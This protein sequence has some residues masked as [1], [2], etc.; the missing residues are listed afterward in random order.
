MTLWP[1]I[2]LSVLYGGCVGSFLNVVIYRLPAGKSLVRPGS[3]CPQCDRSLRW[4]ENIPILSWLVLRARCRSCGASI[5]VQ[6]PLVEAVCAGLFGITLWIYFGTTLRP[7]FFDAGPAATWPLLLIHLVL[8][9]ALLAASVID[10]KLFI[11]PLDIPCLVTVVALLGIPAAAAFS[12]ATRD[13]APAVGGAP[14]SAA[15]GALA[16]LAMAYALLRIGVLPQ[17]FSPLDDEVES[18]DPMD[19]GTPDQWLAYPHPRREMA[20]ELLYVVWPLLGAAAGVAIYIFF[21]E[22]PDAG[23]VPAVSALGGVVMGY[24]VGGGLIWGIRIIGTLAF[25]KEAMGLGDV[26]VLAAIG[27]VY[28]WSDALIVFFLAPFAALAGS[29]LVAGVGKMLKGEVRAIPYGPYLAMAA[30]VWAWFQ[31]PLREAYAT[32]FFPIP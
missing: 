5:S 23:G 18:P 12:P 22:A 19:H 30:I 3:H 21:L 7:A 13:V 9:A 1:W 27:A 11:I 8:I 6:Y 10:L 20:K 15:I 4:F 17:S 31:V 28:G 25:G 26:H 14:T 24:M 32:L 16:G 2:I 29:A